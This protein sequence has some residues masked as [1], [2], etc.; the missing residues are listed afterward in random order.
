MTLSLTLSNGRG[1]SL[2]LILDGTSLLF[3]VAPTPP[4]AQL[5]CMLQEL[6]D[7]KN[8]YSY[9]CSLLVCARRVVS[10]QK[11]KKQTYLFDSP[12]TRPQPLAC[13]IKSPLFRM[14][15]LCAV[16]LRENWPSYPS[17]EK[18]HSFCVLRL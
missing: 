3:R 11:T 15:Y 6:L 17:F 5:K 4:L 1:R 10:R 7:K 14:L 2:H 13:P 9:P 16:L 12:E 8:K 18:G